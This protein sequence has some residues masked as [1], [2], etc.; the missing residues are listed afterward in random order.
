MDMVLLKNGTKEPAGFVNVTLLALEDLQG[1]DP[2][3]LY[4]L[5]EKCRDPEHQLWPGALE[6]LQEL[7]LVRPD[8]TIHESVRNMVLLAVEG[9]GLDIH[10][11]DPYMR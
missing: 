3:A 7:T 2:V 11:G 4:E 6:T 10:V 9:E 8:G 1:S 5:R